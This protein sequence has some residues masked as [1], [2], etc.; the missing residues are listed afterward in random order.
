MAMKTPGQRGPWRTAA[1][2][3]AITAS[4]AG[5]LAL[6]NRL[7]RLGVGEPEP[8]LHGQAGYYPWT[9]GSVHYIARGRGPAVALIHGIYPGASS[10]EYRKVFERLADRYRVFALDL[11]G[12]G[13]SG[14]PAVTYTPGLYVELIEDFL[15][16][17]VGAADHPVTVV[18]PGLSAAFVIHA[19]ARRPDHFSGL[20]LIEPA[21]LPVDARGTGSALA[22]LQRAL[23]RSPLLGE[24]LY[25][26]VVSRPGLR[27]GLGYSAYSDFR[28]VSD[29]IVDQFYTMA[30]Q[31]GAR[32]APADALAG[33]LFTPVSATFASMTTPT[34]ILWGRRD[35]RMPVSRARAF[36]ELR[37]DL[38]L[39][40]FPTGGLPQEEAPDAFLRAL[41]GWMGALARV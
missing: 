20:A 6:A 25:N 17:V 14:R 22:T 5:A 16:Q 37:P 18:A 41:L 38:D 13:L 34:L 9:H 26:L 21:G 1:E 33:A 23:L 35:H 28:A 11:L 40:V 15:S 8:P 27:A 7:A 39:R 10:F 2:I 32:F 19:A 4:A 31:P 3:A 36:Q 30:H 24:A 12:F 29:D